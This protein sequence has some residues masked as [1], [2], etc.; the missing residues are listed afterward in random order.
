MN[1]EKRISKRYLLMNRQLHAAPRGFGGSG[2]RWVD[3]INILIKDYD[4]KTWLDYGCGRET[5]YK[6][7]SHL[8]A[9]LPVG[10]VGHDPAIKEK[11]SN[12]AS[13]ELVTCTDV[14]EHI[15]PKYLDN[16][17]NHLSVLTEKV[18]FL[19]IAMHPAKKKLPNGKNA[20]LIQKPADWWMTKLSGYFP[21]WQTFTISAPKG[22]ELKDFIIYL[23]KGDYA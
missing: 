8:A 3:R 6:S 13:A 16:V 18:L 12:P 10:Y 1:T 4:I 2:Y 20:H 11:S 22:R 23:V 21:H 7:Y 19:N 15:E 9:S 17:L 5:L 14:L